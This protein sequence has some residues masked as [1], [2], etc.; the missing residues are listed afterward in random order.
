M[1]SLSPGRLINSD[2]SRSPSAAVASE[3]PGMISSPGSS[4][5]AL[6]RCLPWA[7][8]VVLPVMRPAQRHIVGPGILAVSAVDLCPVT[9]LLTGTQLSAEDTRMRPGATAPP[10]YTT[11][12]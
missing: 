5:M 10:H 3:A 8:P 4:F 7:D 1:T 9:G 12:T 11:M 2:H 6:A